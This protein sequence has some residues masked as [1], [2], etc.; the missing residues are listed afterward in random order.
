MRVF[1]LL[2]VV[3]SFSLAAGA[4]DLKVKVVDPQIGGGGRGTS[5]AARE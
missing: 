5:V 2:G 1:V 4:A 3:L